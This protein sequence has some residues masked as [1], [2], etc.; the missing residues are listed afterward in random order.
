MTFLSTDTIAA[1]ATAPLSAGVAIIRVSGPDACRA[2]AALCPSFAGVLPKVAHFGQIIDVDKNSIDHAIVIYFQGPKSFT[3]ED[4]VEIQCHGGKAVTD[5]IMQNLLKQNVRQA[6]AG[7]FSKRS[8]L[9]GKM[10]LTEAEGLADLI[11]AETEEQRKLALRQ[12]KGE[13]GTF[14]DDWREKIMHMLA[15]VEAAVDFPDEEL[16]VLEEAGLREK[17]NGLILQLEA[18]L[19]TRAGE[20]LRDGFQVVIL[21]EPNAGKSTLTNLLTGEDTAIVSDI[22]GTTRDVVSS[23]LNIG[24]YPI[25][26]ADTA[27]LRNAEDVIEKE[28]VKRAT[29]KAEQADLILAVVSA[30]DWPNIPEGV[31]KSLKNNAGLIVVSK[32]DQIEIDLPKVLKIG[33]G[34]FSVV[35]ANLENKENLLL[36]SEQLEKLIKERFAGSQQAALLTRERHRTCLTKALTHLNRAKELYVEKTD[37]SLSDLL[38]QDLRDAAAQIGQVTGRTG[39][40]DV[41]DVVF[42]TFCVGK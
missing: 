31:A 38:A 8:V 30:H 15:H 25:V 1:I 41:L 10:D 11:A 27:G 14:F 34:S 3:G 37:I 22:A 33:E 42:S 40:E 21:G 7:E 12:L 28:G 9:N 4:V 6:E 35:G 36:I 5:A 18:A 39:S 23:H 2:V 26:L 32:V 19:S 20:R 29:K 16:E 13:L 17:L 24:G